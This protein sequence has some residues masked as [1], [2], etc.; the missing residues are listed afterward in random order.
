MSRDRSLKVVLNARA[1]IIRNVA[2][3]IVSLVT[4]P[5]AL[6]ALGTVG[7]GTFQ[8][9]VSLG[10]LAAMTDVGL[11][12]AL[13]T[14]VGQLAGAGQHQQIRHTIGGALAVIAMVVVLVASASVAILSSI[15]VLGLLKVPPE[16]RQQAM[17]GL[18]VVL[19]AFAIRMPLS[20]FTSAHAGFQIGDRVVAW[21]VAGTLLAP[22]AMVAAAT[23]TRRLDVA[24][25][26]QLAVS[27]AATIGAVQRGFRIEPASRPAFT[28]RDLAAGWA[29]LRSGFFYYMLQLEV[30]IISGLDNLVIARVIGVE[31]VAIY[32]V[33]NRVISLAFSMV[34]SLGASFWG[35]VS[36]AVGH[37]D[38]PWI[39]SEATRLRRVGSLWMAV[40]AGGFAAVGVPV[41]ALWTGN[42]IQVD[43]LLPIALGGYFALLGHTMIDA[44]ILNGAEKIRQQI[45]T[46]ALDAGLNLALSIWLA[47]RIGYVGVGFGTLI[48]YSL[49][50]FVPMQ[51]FSWRLVVGGE[52]P[53][54]WTRSLTTV[55]LSIAC[56]FAINQ[57]LPHVVS[58]RLAAVIVGGCASLA[59]TLALTR[60]L[61]GR[62][63][64]QT[65][66]RT[67]RRAA[68]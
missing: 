35:G 17:A 25:G 54:F 52:R 68:P 26:V 31:A 4:V 12:L 18:Y 38:I 48:A 9:L 63:G 11:G 10:N 57:L 34:Y 5:L 22:I 15:D 28:L 33:A 27:L 41:I 45:L 21:N 49:C 7:Y 55:V 62:D 13:L 42:R 44:S 56:G 39:R 46:V 19:A 20:V 43:P 3:V 58:G 67:F 60:I 47:H 66:V 1:A 37:G 6:R 14:R 16:L 50:T 23:T 65:L 8:V 30:T 2:G 61:V 32:S 40:F 51:Y 24:I 59:A 36:Q 29:M 64:V 53:P